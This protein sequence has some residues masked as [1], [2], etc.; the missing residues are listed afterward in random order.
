MLTHLISAEQCAQCRLCCNFCRRSA[1]EAP[2][3]TFSLT[4]RLQSHGILI[5]QRPDGSMTFALHFPE[6]APDDYCADCPMLDPGCGCTLPRETRPIE[7]RL[8]PVRLMRSP[9]GRL[10]LGLY[11]SCPAIAS[12]EVR[13]RIIRETT[14][15]LLPELLRVA[16]EQ[17]CIVRPFDPAYA[18]IWEE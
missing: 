9:S 8:W 14:G 13:F 4:Q 16:D 7:C 12:P 6:N 3:L 10:C 1:W 2:A 11:E 5:C 17:P 18:I 15:P